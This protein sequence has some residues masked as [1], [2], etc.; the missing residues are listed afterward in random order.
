MGVVASGEERKEDFLEVK[1]PTNQLECDTYYIS[2]VT[3]V[4]NWSRI[5][6]KRQ[7]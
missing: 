1:G 7:S 3:Y 6:M 4:T 2:P 5:I